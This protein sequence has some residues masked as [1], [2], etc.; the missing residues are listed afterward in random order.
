M[1]NNSQAEFIKELQGM[2]LEVRSGKS[3]HYKVYTRDG[4][5]VMDF[6]KTPSDQHWRKQATRQLTHKLRLI[7]DK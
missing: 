1:A 7:Y 6:A 4:K 5:W 3:N 2:G